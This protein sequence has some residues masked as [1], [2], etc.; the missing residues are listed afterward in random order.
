MHNDL[1]FFIK[2]M[3]IKKK[4]LLG[5]ISPSAFISDPYCLL[6]SVGQD[7]TQP[8]SGL[9]ILP[10]QYNKE[11]TEAEGAHNDLLP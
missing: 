11:Q 4:R 8:G 9:H 1:G 5:N 10:T 6:S 2:P 7:S 3:S